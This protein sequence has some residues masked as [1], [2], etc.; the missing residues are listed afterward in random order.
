MA[1]VV[2]LTGALYRTGAYFTLMMWPT[3]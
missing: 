1:S 2:E 3:E